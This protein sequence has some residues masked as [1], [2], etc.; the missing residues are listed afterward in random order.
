MASLLHETIK[1]L[2]TIEE[3]KYGNDLELNR[4]LTRTVEN[5][6]KLFNLQEKSQLTVLI[7]TSLFPEQKVIFHTRRGLPISKIDSKPSEIQEPYE[8]QS[9]K[10]STGA[11]YKDLCHYIGEKVDDLTVDNVNR[12]IISILESRADRQPL[13]IKERYTRLISRFSHLILQLIQLETDAE[14]SLLQF[15]SKCYAYELTY[16]LSVNKKLEVLPSSDTENIMVALDRLIEIPDNTEL[17]ESMFSYSSESADAVNFKCSDDYFEKLY[18]NFLQLSLV[19]LPEQF[20][21]QSF[22]NLK[23]MIGL[24]KKAIDADSLEL[25]GSKIQDSKI[26]K[27]ANFM[28]SL[29]KSDSEEPREFVLNCIE[30]CKQRRDEETE[31]NQL[32]DSPQIHPVQIEPV[33]ANGIRMPTEDPEPPLIEEAKDLISNLSAV[34]ESL[35][36]FK[37]DVNS[38]FPRCFRHYLISVLEKMPDFTVTRDLTYIQYTANTV[39]AI[40]SY[41]NEQEIHEE[42]GIFSILLD[43][44][45]VQDM[46]ISPQQLQTL[47]MREAYLD[48][49]KTKSGLS[50][51]LR[52][53]NIKVLSIKQMEFNSADLNNSTTRRQ[54]KQKLSNWYNRVSKYNKLYEHATIY[55]NKQ[56]LTRQFNSRFIKPYLQIAARET[57]GDLYVLSRFFRL[58]NRHLSHLEEK[59]NVAENEVQRKI[60][61]IY[62]RKIACVYKQRQEIHLLASQFRNQSLEIHNKKLEKNLFYVW[63]A[64]LQQSYLGTVDVQ[65]LFQETDNRMRYFVL[66]KP[67]TL[68]VTR[69]K[70]DQSFKVFKSIQRDLLLKALLTRWVA[71]SSLIKHEKKYANLK[72]LHIKKAIFLNWKKDCQN[73][74]KAENLSRHYLLA[75][76]FRQI[77]LAAAER[78]LQ[79]TQNFLVV[80]SCWKKWKLQNYLHDNKACSAKHA[81][82]IWKQKSQEVTRNHLNAET[83]YAIL[84]KRLSFE[85]WNRFYLSLID[86]KD[87]ADLNFQ[88]IF[89]NRFSRKLWSYRSHERFAENFLQEISNQFE[90]KLI[91]SLFQIW[92]FKHQTHFEN[93]AQKRIL[94]FQKNTIENNLLSLSFKAWR[95]KKISLSSRKI[96]LEYQLYTYNTA[97]VPLQTTFDK[98]VDATNARF[99]KEVQAELFYLSKVSGKIW[100]IWVQKTANIIRLLNVQAENIQDRKEYDLVVR[101]LRQWYYKHAAA[102]SAKNSACN[103][104]MEKRRRLNL[105]TMFD[106]WK[107]KLSTEYLEDDDDEYVEADS[108]FMSNPSP[109]ARKNGSKPKKPKGLKNFKSFEGNSNTENSYIF[110][111][112]THFFTPNKNN[113]PFTPVRNR[114]SPT[115]LQETNQRIRLDRLDALTKRF[116]NANLRDDSKVGVLTSGVIPR[117]SPPKIGSRPKE[118]GGRPPAPIF[119]E[120]LG[121]NSNSSVKLGSIENMSLTEKMNF[122]GNTSTMPTKQITGEVGPLDASSPSRILLDDE[123]L[124]ATAKTENRIKPIVINYEDV[125]S[126]LHYSNVDTLKDR[127]KSTRVSPRRLNEN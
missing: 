105:K 110:G 55:S 70:L 84:K 71:A 40:S 123:P 68:W 58:W 125:P 69:Q 116:R 7:T 24:Y 73:L 86:R 20:T 12:E 88:R 4:L 97:N 52:K 51:H 96:E 59:R 94:Q 83:M 15:L 72:R 61:L 32:A 75:C 10:F 19:N 47:L 29:F 101:L 26:E 53:W 64:H 35:Y 79:Y 36:D 67:F 80:E 42:S 46:L 50:H 8:I 87:V 16:Y 31:H 45:T 56:L 100:R 25:E 65:G 13:R 6:F 103:A 91:Q 66:K 27:I 124:L 127:L 62:I 99:D 44:Q 92:I 3:L 1:D 43:L 57:R 39:N 107:Y 77:Q 117:L 120:N 109:L 121:Y 54:L 90:R 2:R 34:F 126:E 93:K 38:L 28:C 76:H 60:C 14:S 98:W 82:D 48:F 63:R 74:M 49:L 33:V 22:A 23:A 17:I 85:T 81:F 106:L 102:L 112:E 115:R 119:S 114:T 89:L 5:I 118:R 111:N 95:R 41:S 9:L 122:D 78:K 21:H 30:K 104:F 37:I 18:S 113:S 11:T 108:T